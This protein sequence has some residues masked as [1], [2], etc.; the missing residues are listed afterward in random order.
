MLGIQ[1]ECLRTFMITESMA[2]MLL[3]DKLC[4]YQ[5]NRFYCTRLFGARGVLA[6]EIFYIVRVC[7]Q[8]IV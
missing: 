3:D 4:Y 7:Y 6:I 1:I 2:D 5:C 8:T